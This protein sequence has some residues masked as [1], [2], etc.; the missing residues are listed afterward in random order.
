MLIKV[1]GKKEEIMIG[2][3]LLMKLSTP[4]LGGSPYVMLV[5]LKHQSF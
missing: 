5:D 3:R 4:S 1:P 2:S